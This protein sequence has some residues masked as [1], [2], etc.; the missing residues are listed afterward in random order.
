MATNVIRQKPK[1]SF[2]FEQIQEQLVYTF[3][4][5]T[6]KDLAIF[7]RQFAAMFNGNTAKSV[8]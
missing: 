8:L 6:I 7:A 1:G 5:V 3:S 4:S 2:S